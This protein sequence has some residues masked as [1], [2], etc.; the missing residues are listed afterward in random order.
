M[1]FGRAADGVEFWRPGPH[2]FAPARVSP[3]LL[4]TSRSDLEALIA[5]RTRDVEHLLAA[6]DWDGAYYLAGYLVEYALKIC[7]VKRLMASDAYPG[8]NDTA[9]YYTHDFVKL[10]RLAA[11]DDA[12]DADPS[13][14]EPWDSVTAW[15]EGARYKL[16][17][18]EDTARKFFNSITGEVLPWIRTHS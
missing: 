7:I 14:E 15:N 8:R 12:M 6:G 11:L 2:R 13:M 9:S 10:R 4:I 18:T 16:G 17:T 3:M 5:V 1:A